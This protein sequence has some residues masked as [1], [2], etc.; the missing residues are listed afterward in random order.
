MHAASGRKLSNFSVDRD[1]QRLDISDKDDILVA[2]VAVPAHEVT[3]AGE[4]Q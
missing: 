3:C 2:L 4:V 1:V